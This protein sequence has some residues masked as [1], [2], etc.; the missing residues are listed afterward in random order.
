MTTATRT[1]QPSTVDAR[2]QFIRRALAAAPPMS[3][4]RR[5]RIATVLFGQRD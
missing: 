5:H 3:A 1:E 2:E 4:E